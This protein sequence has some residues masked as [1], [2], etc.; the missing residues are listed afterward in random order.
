MSEERAKVAPV[1]SPSE[2]SAE[3]YEQASEEED[4]DP[5]TYDGSLRSREDSF[6]EQAA[7]GPFTQN[8]LSESDLSFDQ[9]RPEHVEQELERA[10]RRRQRRSALALFLTL[11]LVGC[12]ALGFLTGAFAELTRFV[13]SQFESASAA[14]KHEVILE[15]RSIP[16]GADIFEGD[17]PMALGKSPLRLRWNT[18]VDSAPRAFRFAKAQHGDVF[19]EVVAPVDAKK[20]VTLLREVVLPPQ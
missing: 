12:I 6:A 13:Q 17:A 4:L 2:P 14:P 20:S 1:A 5:T 10:H 11:I 18:E 8:S 16:S 9:E 15:L 19:L 3:A 7:P